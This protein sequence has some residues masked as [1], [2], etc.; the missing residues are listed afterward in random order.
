[1]EMAEW[2]K[3]YNP[4]MTIQDGL[5]DPH[6]ASRELD[7]IALTLRC[8]YTYKGRKL[9]GKWLDINVI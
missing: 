4:N 8:A 9:S 7:P 3:A 6:E 1:M 2:P 5:R